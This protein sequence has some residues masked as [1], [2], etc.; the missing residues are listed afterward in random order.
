ML[1]ITRI[2]NIMETRILKH[3]NIIYY[4]D[5]K[6]ILMGKSIFVRKVIN[7]SG[8]MG[9]QED[10]KEYAHKIAESRGVKYVIEERK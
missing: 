4:I 9:T 6:K 3:W 2:T 5:V 7:E 1:R 10:V 8:Y